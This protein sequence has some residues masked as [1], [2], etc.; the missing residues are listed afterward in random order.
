MKGVFERRELALRWNTSERVEACV[1][2]RC[3]L[4]ISLIHNQFGSDQSRTHPLDKINI[5][6]FYGLISPGLTCYLNCI[7][8]VLFM[9]EEFR[10]RIKR[11]NDDAT[12]LD[13]RMK[14]LFTALEKNQA[15]T[16][17][18]ARILGI[19]D[20][21][22]QRDAAEYFEKMLCLMNPHASKIF[23]GGLE[24]TT[25]CCTCKSR[26]NALGFFWI[27]PLSIKDPYGTYIVEKGFEDYFRKEKVSGE[28][29]I[30]C[31][32]CDEK[33]DAIVMCEMTQ[34][35]EILTLLLKR[36][37]YNSYLQGNVKVDCEA[38]VPL[39]LH[40]KDCTYDLYALVKH[41]GQLTG[42]H[43]VA[44]IYSSQTKEWY[45]F[46]DETVRLERK[47]M[48]KKTYLR[49]RSSYLLMYKKRSRNPENR[50]TRDDDA[51]VEEKSDEEAEKDPHTALQT[52]KHS[53]RENR[54]RSR[55][56][57]VAMEMI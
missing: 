47:Y 31:G 18:I 16:H 46:N 7:L 9:T 52:P 49:S 41:Y 14:C 43:Y 35:P 17:D 32:T 1:V 42:G 3:S 53:T 56:S 38:Q 5:S 11:C 15:R 28:N 4:I 34:P 55:Q 20:V 33:Q 29:K 24:H 40:I 26:N 39:V 37:H 57:E 13:K 6:D 54:E 48:L 51:E 27:L 50:N 8:Q 10:A 36:F 19:A 22:E 12:A 45:S 2:D 44:L 23:K 30:Y 21:Y 25:T